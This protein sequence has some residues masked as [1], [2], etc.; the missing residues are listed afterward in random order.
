[1]IIGSAVFVAWRLWTVMTWQ[2]VRIAVAGLWLMALVPSIFELLGVVVVTGLPLGRM[3]SGMLPTLV[4]PIIYATLW[5]SYL[6]RSERVANTY[7]RY[8]EEDELAVIFE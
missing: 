2:S 1:M 3:L 4:R 6:L 7:A 8:P 5:T